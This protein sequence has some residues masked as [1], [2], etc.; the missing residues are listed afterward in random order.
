ML[1]AYAKHDL[2]DDFFGRAEEARR[3]NTMKE[4]ISEVASALKTLKRLEAWSPDVKATDEF[5]AP[6]FDKYFEKLDLPNLLKKSDYHILA[7]LVPKNK[8]DP[9][10]IDKLDAIVETAK[11]AKPRVD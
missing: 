8:I 9:E 6:L 5:L 11:N 3:L 2:P 7:S 4:S 1:L 10:I